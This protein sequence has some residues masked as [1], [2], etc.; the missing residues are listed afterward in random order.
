MFTVSRT[1]LFIG[2]V[3]IAFLV[4]GKSVFGQAVAIEEITVTAR[5]R[6]E[7][8]QDVPIAVS[9]FSG[10]FIETLGF[11]E[12]GDI[13]LFVP[14]FTW[15]TEFGRASPQPYLRG[16]GTN[17]FNPINNGPIAIY[18]DN[19]FIGPNV[20]QGFATFD[21]QRVEVLK[22]PQGS[23]YGRNSTGGLINFISVRPEIGGGSSGYV[24]TEIGRYET[25]GLDGAWGFDLGDSAAA[26]IS[27]L[28]EVNSGSFDNVNPV[29]SG[30]AGTVDDL[31]WRAQMLFD[32]GGRT[33]VLLNAHYGESDT[34]VTP[35]K[36]IGLQAVNPDFA[37]DG[38]NPDPC[39]NPRLGANCTD[40]FTGFVDHPD[41]FTTTKADDSEY[42][43]TAGVF[44][45]VDHDLTDNLSLHSISSYDKADFARYDDVDDGAI[46][47][48][49]DYFANEFEWFSEELRL[50]GTSARSDW[51]VGLYYYKE[52]TDGVQ[53][54]TNPVFG[55]GEGNEHDVETTSYA[56]FGNYG[57]SISDRL[58]FTGGLRWTYEEKDVKKYNGF[59][60]IIVNPG[61]LGDGNLFSLAE[62]MAKG[63]IDTGHGITVGN[64]NKK[65]WDEL[66]GRLSIDYTT[67][68]GHLIYA[69]ISRGFKGGDV[70]GSAFLDEYVTSDGAGGSLICPGEEA[71][72]TARCSDSVAAFQT[73]IVP[74]DPEVLDAVEVGFK[75]DL[76]DGNL[77][78]NGAVFYYDYQD[79]Q[80]TILAPVPGVAGP[81]TTRL[82]N[83]ARSK[84]P[85]AEVEV[86]ATPS[87]SWLLQVNAGWLD[88]KYD[89]FGD[90]SG[91]QISLTPE[92][93][94]SALGRYNLEL[95]GGANIAF[96]TSF[97]WQSETFFQ[98]TNVAVLEE[99]SYG[100]W[101]AR[102]SYTS[103]DG[104]FNVAL[105]GRNLANKEYFGS[106]F[107]VS[108]L[109]YM[110]VKPGAPRYVGL[111]AAYNFGGT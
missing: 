45:Q 108:A 62:L 88:A 59:M 16:I 6:D 77:R 57:R 84:F 2:L 8:L 104:R 95:A 74:V 19:V 20:A 80:N 18:Q 32:A 49:N 40:L 111:T 30:E 75:G 53:M 39:P 22:G 4:P 68:E 85:G 58:R 105:Y 46:G 64:P 41:I 47:L 91:N 48:E 110:A 44:V 28:R 73:K 93:Q 107:D 82:E 56:L 37:T 63:G 81:G 70:N 9:A 102:L 71:P 83:A 10:D 25:F 96:Q 87:N 55:N 79:Q 90:N 109:G 26:R 13:A 24:R 100:L 106:G 38:I 67:A 1:V 54:W 97:F 43:E 3:S 94:F 5:K 60:P 21:I 65:D 23:L 92:W 61:N 78:L 34:D 33:Q 17:N 86:I 101:G 11:K 42:V 36:N 99:G 12:S 50:S 14:N 76:V 66:S 15:H 51:Q 7:S 98:P 103:G 35:F 27:V 69:S 72:G 52:Q 29:S 31:A 89:E